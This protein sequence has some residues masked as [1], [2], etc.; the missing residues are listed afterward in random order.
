MRTSR[1]KQ[2]R[3]P[4]R[5]RTPRQPCELPFPHDAIQA[6]ERVVVGEVMHFGRRAAEQLK[7][8]AVNVSEAFTFVGPDRRYYRAALKSWS[9]L[10][11]DGL[12][13]EQMPA[14]PESPLKLD[15]VCAF[16]QRQ[17]MLFVCQKATELGVEHILPAFT[18][19]SAGPDR[20]EHEKAHAWPGQAIRAARQCRRATVPQVQDAAPLEEVLASPCWEAAEVRYFL[21]DPGGEGA[22]GEGA[23]G[24]GAELRRGAMRVCLAVGPEGGWSAG[25]RRA[26]IRAGA[27][28]L[29]L[30]GR[31]LRAETA[32]V[33]GLTVLQYVL[34]DMDRFA[35]EP[36]DEPPPGAEG[37]ARQVEG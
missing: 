23:G 1:Q 18:E 19:K 4:P 7:F 20:L 27:R 30:G 13:Y 12:V 2:R 16:L 26:L 28:P 3:I 10:G 37:E 15:L 11:C 31:I 32:V 21:D 35:V 8:R 34:G 6:P 17:R 29:A 36:P 5:V 22:G 14:S 24:E 9:P 33:A 25:E